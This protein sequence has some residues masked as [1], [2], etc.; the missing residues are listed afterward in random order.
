MPRMTINGTGIE[1][2]LLGKDGDPPVALTPGGRFT[3][4]VPGLREM[5]DVFVKAGRQVLIYDRPNCGKS[6]VCLAGES[7]SEC[8]GQSFSRLEAIIEEEFKGDDE[9]V[10]GKSKQEELLD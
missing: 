8:E 10:G 7:E 1:Y 9:S 3:M 5:A 2:E 6:D 4:E